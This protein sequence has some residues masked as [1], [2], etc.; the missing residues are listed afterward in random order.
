MGDAQRSRFCLAVDLSTHPRENDGH[1]QG[2][3]RGRDDPF[4][5]DAGP[6]ENFPGAEQLSL[7]VLPAAR[8]A[9]D[10][11]QDGDVFGVRLF[12]ERR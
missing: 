1:R 2:G 12:R 7:D 9:P 8:I 3:E 11:A 5:P 10:R 4:H 6:I